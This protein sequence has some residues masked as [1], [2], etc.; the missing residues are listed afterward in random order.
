MTD[1]RL[2]QGTAE[3]VGTGRRDERDGA[4]GSLLDTI[5]DR[6][7]SRKGR[8]H[9]MHTAHSRR[10]LIV[11]LVAAVATLGSFGATGAAVAA[12]G[13]AASDL[14]QEREAIEAGKAKV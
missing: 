9:H 12:E 7:R 14:K 13:A 4:R 11:A 8:S 2:R 6:S 5:P 10:A 1:I 3:L